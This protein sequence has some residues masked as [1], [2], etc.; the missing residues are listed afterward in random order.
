MASSGAK[1]DHND[2]E[3]DEHGD[4]VVARSVAVRGESGGGGCL[5]TCANTG[6]AR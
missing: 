4:K 2:R 5:E 3:E 6:S 1:T